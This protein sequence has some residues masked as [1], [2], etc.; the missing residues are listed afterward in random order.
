ME[1]HHSLRQNTDFL[2]P[3]HTPTLLPNISMLVQVMQTG[4]KLVRKAYEQ[5]QWG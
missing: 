4:M 5:K 2:P 3:S 1:P